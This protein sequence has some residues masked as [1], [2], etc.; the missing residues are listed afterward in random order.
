M[1]IFINQFENNIN[2]SYSCFDRVIIRGYIL[3]MFCLGGVV[4][5][6]RAMGFYSLSNGVMR[7]FTDQFV[8]HV[9]KLAEKRGIPILWWES[10]DGGKN[11]DKLRYVH[12]HYAKNIKPKG[13]HVYC[14]IA[15]RE[16]AKTFTCRNLISRKGDP[17]EKLYHTRKLVKHYY[18]YF[19]DS[20]LGGPCYLKLST[21]FPFHAE[22]YFNGHNAVALELERR[23]IGYKM[24]DNAF[25][26]I[27]DPSVVQEI[28]FSLS[29]EMVQNRIEYW[30]DIFFKFDKGTYSTRSKYLKHDWYLSQTEICTN[31][32]FKS[33][34]FCISLFERLLDKYSR[35]GLP[36]SLSMIFARRRTRKNMKRGKSTCR[37]HDNLACAKHWLQVNSAKFY[38]KLNYFMRFE[39]TIND[40]KLLGLSKK[41]QYLRSY[42]KLGIETN[43]RF[44]NC[45]ADVDTRSL[46]DGESEAMNQPFETEKGQKIPAVDMRKERQVALLKELLKQKY[47]F[48]GFRTKE[49]LKNLPNS[50]RNS[51]EIRYELKKLRA[52]NLV[53]KKKSQSFYR[54]TALGYKLLF[55]KYVSNSYF[56]KPMI[57][58]TCR[59]YDSK[60]VSQPS[61]L[62]KGY[63][64]INEGLS[65]VTKELFIHRAS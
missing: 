9:E 51:A 7:I 18:I 38:N 16:L 30:M 25:I 35:I 36:D 28:A 61:K 48:H 42:L 57:S 44:M 59:S 47:S 43:N 65:V 49:L 62:E 14:I 60:N 56:E 41:L 64:M 53:E 31:I 20:L 5:F 1:D 63:D 46:S 19:Y 2:S 10:V 27:E 45:M 54:V 29:G 15:V 22:F 6:L 24:K 50:Y 13:N 12:K 8:S 4:N 17:Y 52:R 58:M 39:T 37:L 26:W 40:P 32:I 34:N 3:S 21:Y 55:L 33:T 11:G 23:G